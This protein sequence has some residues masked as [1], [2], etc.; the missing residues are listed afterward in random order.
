MRSH[1]KRLSSFEAV[2]VQIGIGLNSG[3]VVVRSIDNDLNIDYSALGHT[4]HLAA[5]M[6]EIAGPGEALISLTTLR[7]VEGFVQIKSLGPI[8]VK[9]VSQPVEVYSLTAATAART[10][11]QA[12]A[13]RGLTPL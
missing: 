12:G 4:T 8:Q 3:E 9:G 7:Q 1:G 11:V 13:T 5:R 2:D 6:Q 10:R